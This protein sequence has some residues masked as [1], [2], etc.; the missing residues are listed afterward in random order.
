MEIVN[1]IC[2]HCNEHIIGNKKVFANHV[3]WC[4]KNP[5]YEEIRNSTITKLKKYND[6]FYKIFEVIC[7]KCGKKFEVREDYRK[8]PTKEKYFCCR[9]CANSH[10]RT[11][12][13]KLKTSISIKNKLNIQPKVKKCK[14]CGKEFIGK[15]KFC[16][17]ECLKLY[18]TRN[19]SNQ[20]LKIYLSY[21][22][23]TF[24]LNNYPD[25]FDFDLIQKYGWYKA[26][27]HGDNLN[28]ISRDHKFSKLE[29]WE[30]KIDPYIISHP[31][32][33]ELMRHNDN[34]SKCKKC[35]ISID[36]LVCKI[37][38][39]NKKYGYYENKINYKI[40]DE[41]GISFS[42]IYKD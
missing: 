12:E 25:E 16:S 20:K 11:E 13:S 19:S 7:F 24:S 15:R 38:E 10:I 17:D 35:S 3:R 8:F 2:P 30:Q 4:K 33:C 9:S 23:F 29:G 5:K 27:N 6:S 1:S 18:K 34:S 32:N 31:A 22:K 37:K 21:C 28:G 36:D 40:F 41:L 14:W 39:W 26:K 42:L